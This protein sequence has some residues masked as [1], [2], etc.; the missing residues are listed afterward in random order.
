M[1]GVQQLV[2]FQ[3]PDERRNTTRLRQ[4]RSWSI[5]APQ[6]ITA[7]ADAASTADA[8]PRSLSK[9]LKEGTRKS[10]RAAENV[11]FVRNFI[12]GRINKDIYKRMVVCLWHV[13]RA[14]EEECRKNSSNPIYGSLPPPSWSGCL[15][16]RILPTT[17]GAAG[18]T[19]G[20]CRV[21]GTEYVDRIRE[22]GASS[23][24]LLVA[25]AYTRYLGDLSGG[26][27]L[28]G[29]QEGYAA[30]GGRT[31]HGL[32]PFSRDEAIGAAVQKTVSSAARRDQGQARGC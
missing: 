2:P 20:R 15:H 4:Y 12:K 19:P 28:M 11:H 26:Q 9:D 5:V 13:Y 22:V 18:A 14:L 31:G 1:P 17:L 27:V 21:L 32:L 16:G 24:N 3:K 6:T 10:H 23:P 29:G 30:A 7:D 25:H 8:P